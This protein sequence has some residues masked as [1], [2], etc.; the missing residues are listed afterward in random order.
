MRDSTHFKSYSASNM[1]RIYALTETNS[2]GEVTSVELFTDKQVAIN[3]LEAHYLYEKE[4]AERDG[5]ADDLDEIFLEDMRG[6]LA[7]G[8]TRFYWQ[9]IEATTSLFNA[10][11]KK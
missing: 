4:N 8:D 9:V 2:N 6:E 1:E 3:V 11:I 7:Y 5:Y 10:T